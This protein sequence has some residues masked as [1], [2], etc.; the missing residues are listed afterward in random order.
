VTRQRPIRKRDLL[1]ARR[2]VVEIC[3]EIGFGRIDGMIIRDR[4]PEWQPAP[5]IIRGI[6][7]CRDDA[8][9]QVYPRHDCA[10]KWHFL[11][12]FRQIDGIEG[13]AT[14]SITVQDGLPIR[15]T[16]EQF[17]EP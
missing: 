4:Q 2:R 11:A 12:L 7:L 9:R 3:Q 10:L 6:L 14:V 17:A 16:I 1:A 8:R 15:L 13:T 5:R